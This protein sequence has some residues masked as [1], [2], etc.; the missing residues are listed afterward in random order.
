MGINTFPATTTVAQQ[1]LTLRQTLTS[2]GSGK[3]FIPIV[4]LAN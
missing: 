1:N 2:S 4:S 3:D